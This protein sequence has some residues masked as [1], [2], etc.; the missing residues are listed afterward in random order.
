MQKGPCTGLRTPVQLSGAPGAEADAGAA[1]QSPLQRQRH[2]AAS[3]TQLPAAAPVAAVSAS[4]GAACAPR[5]PPP[6]QW[7]HPAAAAGGAPARSEQAA[8]AA[9][10]WL[11]PDRSTAL[12]ESM[13]CAWMQVSPNSRAIARMPGTCR[14]K[15]A[16]SRAASEPPLA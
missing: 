12:V 13:R 5:P 2:G 7:L 16:A 10:L 3:A 11:G 15:G 8:A 9:L 14:R 1:A 6:P 4:R